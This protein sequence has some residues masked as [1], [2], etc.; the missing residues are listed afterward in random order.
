M[1]YS[2]LLGDILFYLPFPL[3]LITLVE[4]AILRRYAP[5][6]LNWKESTISFLDEFA[7]VLIRYF[8]PFSVAIP[9]FNFAYEHR[10][11]TIELDS[12]WS[13]VLLFLLADFGYYWYHR[14]SH[15]IRWFWTMHAVH[16]S[17]NRFNL[18]AIWRTGIT[19]AIIGVA[20]FWVPLSWI[21][22]R[23]TDVYISIAL[24]IIYQIWVHNTWMPKLG[25]LEKV[26]NTPSLH[27]VHHAANLEY[28]DGNYGGVLI[29]FDRMFGTY[30]EERDD[31]PI[32][33][34]LVHPMTSNN[35]FVVELDQLISLIKDL[36]RAKNIRSFLGYLS[37]PPGWSPDGNGSTTEEL[38][39]QQRMK[40][41][42][43]IALTGESS[44]PKSAA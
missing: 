30:I 20:V 18:S 17:T 27:R 16:H 10:L 11:F 24:V 7:H 9:A 38:R 3:Y 19:S 15:R 33:Y 32:R 34:G 41:E 42:S 5:D 29:I 2:K 44:S 26:L 1:D 36:A 35:F 25:W 14:A 21:G 23:P 40:N 6:T 43:K 22:F 28:L 39:A 8:V 31:L 13:V 12:V 37:M 4:A